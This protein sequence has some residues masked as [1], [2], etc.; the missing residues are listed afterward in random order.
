LAFPQAKTEMVMGRFYLGAKNTTERISDIWGVSTD[1][2]QVSTPPALAPAVTVNHK[3]P[4]THRDGSHWAVPRTMT[5]THPH[6]GHQVTLSAYGGPLVQTT[7][8]VDFSNADPTRQRSMHL[9]E[10]F[11]TYTCPFI[12]HRQTQACLHRFTSTKA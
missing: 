5:S 10:Y 8:E 6:L 7:S 9:V 3:V 11:Y 2:L 4:F 12:I 1:L